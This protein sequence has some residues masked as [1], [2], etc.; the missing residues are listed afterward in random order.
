[1]NQKL[2]ACL[3]SALLLSTN[4]YPYNL[5]EPKQ[6]QEQVSTIKNQWEGKRV[7]FLGDSITDKNRIGTKKCY[8]EYLAE[9]LGLSPYVY[10]I[11]GNQMSDIL[12]QAQKLLEEQGDNIDAI[13]IFAGTNDYN[14]GV[15][16]GEWYTETEIETEVSGRKMERRKHREPVLSE[17]TFKGRINQ[18]L[19]FLKTHYPTKQ[20]IL[21]TPI[22]RGYAC[23]GDNN[24]QPDEL[25]PNKIGIYVDEY[26][27]TVKE[28][29]NV[30]A[31]PVIDLNSVSGLYPLNDSHVR[32][33]HDENKDRLHPNADGHY[34]M[35][36]A[37]QYQLL[38]FPASFE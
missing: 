38:A 3:L 32:Y 7:A 37:L 29:G 12:K 27:R 26:I 35:A 10:G 11:N 18:A 8:W 33:F 22:H 6:K 23:F 28:A 15:P 5:S 14:A 34:R 24:I 31:V 17:T 9:L 20:I 16:L 30:W 13:L 21:L 19:T 25:F 4:V 36:K 2:S 1:M